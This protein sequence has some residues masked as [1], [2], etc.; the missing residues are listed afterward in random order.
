[1]K[2]RRYSGAGVFLIRYKNERFEVL[3]GRRSTSHGFGQWAIPGGKLEGR[4]DSLR[5][6]AFRELK[7]ETG[8]NLKHIQHSVLG[9]CTK[10][11]PFFLWQTYMVFI[12]KEEITLMPHE[13]FNLDWV[14]LE[15]VNNHDL[16]ISLAIELKAAGKLLR[17]HERDISKTADQTFENERYINSWSESEQTSSEKE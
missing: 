14:P 1:M 3:L 7:E 6:C 9:R 10:R 12:W 8:I 5:D 2:I 16:W 15:E 11:I 4:D 13:F 17:I